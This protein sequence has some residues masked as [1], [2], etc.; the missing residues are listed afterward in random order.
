MWPEISLEHF[1]RRRAQ[2]VDTITPSAINSWVSEEAKRCSGSK[3]PCAPTWAQHVVSLTGGAF[4]FNDTSGTLLSFRGW[5]L[6]D[7]QVN[8]FGHFPL[9]PLNDFIVHLQEDQT[10]SLIEIDDRVG[11]YGRLYRRPADPGRGRRCSTTTT[12]AISEYVHLL[13]RAVVILGGRGSWNLGSTCRPRPEHAA[14]LAQ[15]MDGSTIMGFETDGREWVY[16]KFR[17]ASCC[18]RD[19]PRQEKLTVTGR[20]EAF[21]TDET[22]SEMSPLEQRARLVVDRGVELRAQRQC[23]A[24]GRGAQR[25]L[26]ARGAGGSRARPVPG[27]DDVPA[28]HGIP[29]VSLARPATALAALVP[30]G[31]RGAPAG[32]GSARP[33]SRW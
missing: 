18:C 22:G 7:E 30:R 8:A 3:A 31:S 32:R 21:E 5:A 28:R 20:I 16:T 23:D 26:D 29:L 9:P 19:R 1:G 14:P 17:S 13:D 6:H 12:A 24:Q 15:A 4:G 33:T 10:R 27:A 25:A 11:F 2:A